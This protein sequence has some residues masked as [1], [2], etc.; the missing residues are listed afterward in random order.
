[1]LRRQR[2]K[3]Y[4]SAARA[5]CGIDIPR[6]ARRRADEDKIGR[7]SLFEKLFDIRR[8]ARIRRVIIGGLK[9]SALILENL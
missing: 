4:L 3:V 9:K 1:M 7:C 6:I 2:L 8:D 5:K